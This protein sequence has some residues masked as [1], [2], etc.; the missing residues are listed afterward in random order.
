MAQLRQRSR[1]LNALVARASDHLSMDPAF[2][3]KDFW[4]MEVLRAAT[5]PIAAVDSQKGTHPVRAIFKGGTSLSRAYGLIERFS[6]DVD[7]LV[8]FPDGVELSTN[9]R[10]KVLKSIRDRVAQHLDLS[11][12]RVVQVFSRRGEKQ[13]VSYI[14]P[15]SRRGA[16]GTIKEGVLLEA[17][18][19]GGDYPTTTFP[20]RSLIANYA[21]NELGGSADDWEEFAELTVEVLGAERTLLEKVALLHD[22]TAR[23][24]AEK[25]TDKLNKAGR[26]V[27]D[28]HRLL[29]DGGV[30]TKVRELGPAGVAALWADIDQHSDA[31]GFSYTPRPAGGFSESPLLDM[32]AECREVLADGYTAAMALVYGEKPSLD[33]CL[34]TIRTH[35]G[36]I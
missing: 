28:V 11:G 26:H 22:C 21:V 35:A 34:D 32:S 33:E 20:L 12:D 1:D 30:R 31:D 2:L 36:L 16:V 24:P 13:Y 19:R 23:F 29:A 7:L 14:Y 27:Y 15:R 4:V 6:E 17:G 9:A 3:E 18:V 10:D 8:A 5:T 25:A